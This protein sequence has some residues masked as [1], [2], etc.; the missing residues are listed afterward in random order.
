MNYRS[1]I[2]AGAL[3]IA[4]SIAAALPAH[5]QNTSQD[6]V[7]QNQSTTQKT[8]I[9]L[10]SDSAT[11]ISTGGNTIQTN[12]PEVQAQAQRAY[13]AIITILKENGALLDPQMHDCGKTEINDP[14]CTAD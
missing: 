5:A 1:K 2:G 11:P 14:A 4:L 7:D 8:C 3:A 12:S 9:G 10:E 13:K 6:L